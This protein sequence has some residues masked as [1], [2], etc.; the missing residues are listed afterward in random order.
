M[1]EAWALLRDHGLPP[2][3]VPLYNTSYVP[4]LMPYQ[5]ASEK[6]ANSQVT[7]TESQDWIHSTGDEGLPSVEATIAQSAKGSV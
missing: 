7:H 1:D 2:H 6:A 4:P 3:G 5:P